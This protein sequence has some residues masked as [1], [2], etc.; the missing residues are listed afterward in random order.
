MK[1][2]S[3]STASSSS[4]TLDK[5]SSTTSENVFLQSH[6]LAR[7]PAV[8][9]SIPTDLESV[10]K[11]RDLDHLRSRAGENMLMV[12]RLDETRN[13]YGSGLPRVEMRFSD[14]LDELQN[15]QKLTLYL[16]TQYEADEDEKQG[17]YQNT[18]ERC[19]PLP[20]LSLLSEF[21]LKPALASKLVLS[22]INLWL[23]RSKD[24]KSSGLHHDFHDNLYILL[25]GRKRF[26]LYPPKSGRELRPHGTIET[27]HKNGLIVYEGTDVREDGLSELEAMRY[28]VEGLEHRMNMAR[29]T[30]DMERFNELEAEYEST[31]EVL[32]DVIMEENEG[33]GSDD[34]D[35][36]EDDLRHDLR[37]DLLEEHEHHKQAANRAANE[38][39]HPRSPSPFEPT[40]KKSRLDDEHSEP[41]SFSGISA[42]DLH[43]YLGLTNGQCSSK[44]AK[45]LK[46]AGKP[47]IVDLRVGEMLYLPASWWHE[48]TSFGDG[49]TEVHMALNYWFHPPDG[50][51]MEEL[52]KDEVVWERVEMGVLETYNKLHKRS[53]K[54]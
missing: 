16:T 8:F 43:A 36:L 45:A 7:K 28:K 44:S 26:I 52:Y 25:S 17:I 21:P 11:W 2:Q 31:L 27:I 33:N 12:E 54:R 47:T 22:Q 19:F 29:K 35:D 14:F 23:G 53:K 42:S 4:L 50:S 3:Q 1:G 30:K 49:G 41:D 48:V 38:K 24:G 13:Q 32:Q 9:D 10:T 46:R 34:F 20:I 40:R 6:V 15:S 5:I 51:S 39:T 18:F 37:H